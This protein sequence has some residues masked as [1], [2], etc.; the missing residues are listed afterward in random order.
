MLDR[1]IV[2]RIK[3]PLKSLAVALNARGIRADQVTW[4]GF[5][6]G[7][8]AVACLSAQLYQWAL[9]GLV[10]NR[11]ADGVDGE[12]ARLQG[13]TDAG[14]FLDIALDFAFYALF[15]LGFALGNP[16]YALPAAVLICSFVGTGSSFLAFASQAEKRGIEHPDFGYKGLYYL[17]GLAEGTE[18]I[19]CFVLMCLFPQHFAAIAYGFAAICFVTAANRIWAGWRTL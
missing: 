3:A 10:L 12:L 8:L 5:A 9:L 17:N 7:V 14:A 4:V 13:P 1:H 15:P 19:V 2:P 18:T 6:L 11:L 16:D